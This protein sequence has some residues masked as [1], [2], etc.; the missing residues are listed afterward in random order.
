MRTRRRTG[1]GLAIAA[2]ALAI[3][4]F[5]RGPRPCRGTFEQVRHGMTFD[6]VCA[7]VGGPPGDYS[8]GDAAP[9]WRLNG[10]EREWEKDAVWIA[11]D[12]CLIVYY[13]D[14]LRAS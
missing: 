2:I 4:L 3:I 12:A 1:L 11:D 9:I 6:E 14:N 10:P 7:T 5:P 8:R 13:D